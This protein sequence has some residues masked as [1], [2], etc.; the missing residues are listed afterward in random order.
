MSKKV[1]K[2][3]S[4]IHCPELFTADRGLTCDFGAQNVTTTNTS[5]LKTEIWKP[6]LRMKMGPEG[7]LLREAGDYSSRETFELANSPRNTKWRRGFMMGFGGV[8][9]VGSDQKLNRRTSLIICD[10]K[11]ITT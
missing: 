5:Y 8:G 10:F 9:R 4:W 1:L 2:H 3:K 6:A 11:D 7:N